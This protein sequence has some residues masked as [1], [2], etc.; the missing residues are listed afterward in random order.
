MQVIKFL[1]NGKGEVKIETS[2][3]EGNACAETTEKLVLSLNGKVL[4]EE[5][6]PEYWN[7]NNAFV[8]VLNHGS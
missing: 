8:C 4:N 7:D 6:K 3:F 1:I 2:G 5:K